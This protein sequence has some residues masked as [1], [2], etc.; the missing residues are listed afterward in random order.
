M[1]KL[2][3]VVAASIIISGLAVSASPALAKDHKVVLCHATGSASNPYTRIKISENALDAHQKESHQHGEDILISESEQCPK[4]AP[5]D[6]L[7]RPVETDPADP[8][9][10]EPTD[11]LDRPVETD[12]VVGSS[13]NVTYVCDVSGNF[14]VVTTIQTR[15]SGA[16]S[17]TEVNARHLTEEEVLVHCNPTPG[18]KPITE[19]TTPVDEELTYPAA[20]PAAEDLVTENPAPVETSVPLTQTQ[21]QTGSTEQEQKPAQLAN[22]GW[23]ETLAILGALALIGGTIL[24]GLKRKLSA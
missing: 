19:P 12:P 10:T 22:T 9:P 5:T 13:Q 2:S 14:E 4:G 20:P 6:W 21:I 7:D 11:W 8:K 3:A 18:D 16:E 1:K 15:T 23:E 17:V 24:I